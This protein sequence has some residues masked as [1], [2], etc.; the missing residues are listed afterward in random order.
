M[1][2]VFHTAPKG[3][4]VHTTL[5]AFLLAGP[6]T[7]ANKPVALPSPPSASTLYNTHQQLPGQ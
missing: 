4:C 2:S 1:T 3:V 7:L 6:L 5:A